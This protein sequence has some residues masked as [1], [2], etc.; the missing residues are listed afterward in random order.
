MT[1]KTETKE[2][3]SKPAK[4]ALKGTTV[5]NVIFSPSWDE[6]FMLPASSMIKFACP[7]CTKKDE[8]IK[9]LEAFAQQVKE[10]MDVRDSSECV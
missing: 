4:T 5:S 10:M 2:E 3:N 6:A 9:E 1:K 8:R 7:D